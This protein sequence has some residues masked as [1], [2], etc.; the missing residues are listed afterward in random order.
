MGVSLLLALKENDDLIVFLSNV[1]Q[2]AVVLKDSDWVFEVGS[3]VLTIL[4]QTC[5]GICKCHHLFLQIISR[6]WLTLFLLRINLLIFYLKESIDLRLKQRV[7]AFY[8]QAAI[9]LER[10][11]MH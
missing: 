10:L 11:D 3:T 4:L 2:A 8:E 5:L 9:R 1:A 6:H 7:S